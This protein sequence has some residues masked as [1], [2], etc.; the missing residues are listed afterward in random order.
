MH[1]VNAPEQV[2]KEL[3]F[4]GDDAREFPDEGRLFGVVHGCEK[5]RFASDEK[6]GSL[7]VDI[8]DEE[9]GEQ[10]VLLSASGFEC[11]EEAFSFF[12]KVGEGQFFNLSDSEA[13]SVLL[14]DFGVRING[15]VCGHGEERGADGEDVRGEFCGVEAGDAGEG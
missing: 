9:G 2:G 3:F 15:L 4:S 12:S 7:F 6:E 1:T 13:F 10:E 5:S 14:V 11:V 8:G